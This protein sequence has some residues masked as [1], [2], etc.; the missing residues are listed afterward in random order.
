MSQRIHPPDSPSMMSTGPTSGEGPHKESSVLLDQKEGGKRALK[1]G[2]KG[3]ES[4]LTRR[5]HCDQLTYG[6]PTHKLLSGINNLLFIFLSLV[7]GTLG[8]Q[9]VFSKCLVSKWMSH[10]EKSKGKKA[11]CVS[12]LWQGQTDMGWEGQGADGSLPCRFL[13]RAIG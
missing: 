7:P 9:Q 13:H 3:P 4:W 12:M 8:T 6:F 10:T 5:T 2:G 11:R 1:G